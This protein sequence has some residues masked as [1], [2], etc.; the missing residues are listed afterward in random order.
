MMID[1]D[2]GWFDRNPHVNLLNQLAFTRP[3]HP[4]EPACGSI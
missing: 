3:W 4:P 2:R 1:L